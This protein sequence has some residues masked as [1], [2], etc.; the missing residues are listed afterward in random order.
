[1]ANSSYTL[2][3]PFTVKDLLDTEGI[4]TTYGSCA[5]DKNIPDKDI[6]AVSRMKAAGAILLGKTTTP[7]FA[8]KVTTDSLLTGITRNPWSHSLSPGGSSGGDCVAVVTGVVPFGVSTDGGG[9]SRIPASTCGIL[10]MKVTIGAIPHESWP[11]HCGNNSS[12]SMNCR[13]PVDL[14]GLFN[15]MS[16]AHRLDPWSRREI[17][18]IDASSVFYQSLASKRALFIPTIGGNIVDDEY[19]AVV[20]EALEQ[21]KGLGL[22][23]DVALDDPTHF[24]PGISTQMMACNL[25]ARVRQMPKDQQEHLGPVLQGLL[26]EEKFRMDG[27]SLQSDAISRSG[28]YDRLEHLL[29]RYDFIFSAT[30]TAPPPLADPDSDQDI[31][32]NG[33]KEAISKW[34]T[35]LSISN[36]TGHPSISIPC[37]NDANN[38]PVGLHAIGGWDREQDLVTLACA[39][40]KFYDWT[41]NCPLE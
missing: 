26:N 8:S 14:S 32:V 19:L 7:E 27:V 6:V 29:S 39:V 37:G 40:S 5:L 35:H 21:L 10:G 20:Q 4:R 34:W 28:T 31:T 9:S 15:T 23:V 22:N 41:K 12:I 33:N 30:L 38:L 24:N 2:G 36:L 1:V 18:S 17:S 13:H 16:G 11:F 25:A 3:V